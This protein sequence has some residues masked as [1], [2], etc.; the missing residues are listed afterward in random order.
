[1]LEPDHKALLSRLRSECKFARIPYD[2]ED[3]PQVLMNRLKVAGKW[4]EFASKYQVGFAGR[5]VNL[6]ALALVKALRERVR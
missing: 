5:F 4:S 3:A 2:D 6:R 1:M